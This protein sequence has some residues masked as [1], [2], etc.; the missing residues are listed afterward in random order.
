MQRAEE[1]VAGEVA[2]IKGIEVKAAHD[3]I[4]AILAEATRERSNQLASLSSE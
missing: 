1:L 2:L 4:Q 3:Q